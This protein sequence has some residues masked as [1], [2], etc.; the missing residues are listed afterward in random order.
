MLCVYI[1]THAYVHTGSCSVRAWG[2]VCHSHHGQKPFLK[3]PLYI[4]LDVELLNKMLRPFISVVDCCWS[5]E[6]V[7]NTVAGLVAARN[8]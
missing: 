1:Y 2:L 4:L 7:C 8:L 5:S 3:E 6:S